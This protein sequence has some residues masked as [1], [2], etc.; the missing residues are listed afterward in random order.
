LLTAVE[1]PVL[2][3]ACGAG[4]GT[5]WRGDTGALVARLR[6]REG[7]EKYVEVTYDL[8]AKNFGDVKHIVQIIFGMQG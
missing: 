3:T 2:P 7:E 8:G 6:D 1:T 5:S 4:G